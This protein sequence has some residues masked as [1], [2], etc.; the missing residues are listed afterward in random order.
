MNSLGEF[1]STSHGMIRVLRVRQMSQTGF[2]VSGVS[3]CIS[4]VKSKIGLLREVTRILFCERNK[5]S[6]KGLIADKS[7]R[8]KRKI[9]K[10]IFPSIQL[11][12]CFSLKIAY[13]MDFFR[14]LSQR[15]TKVVNPKNPYSD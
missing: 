11:V 12:A 7:L 5:K 9:Q 4:L 6:E 15:N 14:I 3:G 1:S 2:P 13:R 8:K 10:W